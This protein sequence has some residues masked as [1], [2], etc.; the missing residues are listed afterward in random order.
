MRTR[1]HRHEVDFFVIP[2]SLLPPRRA[3]TAVHRLL[4]S[5]VLGVALCVCLSAQ[6][7]SAAAD[8]ADS[9]LLER[10]V[11]AAY[12]YKFLSYVD[13]PPA[14]FA[15]PVSPYV[16]AIAGAD[17]VASELVALTK[18]RTVNNRT[19][20]VKRVNFGDSMAGV[21]LLFVGQQEASRQ[22]QWLH[23]G[24]MRAVLTV[25]ENDLRLPEGS[26]INFRQVEG[27][28]R[29]E[30]SLPAAERNDLK[31]SSRMLAVALN[32]QHGY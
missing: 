6:R 12:L 20:T 8:D 10:S 24:T 32:V 25:T 23:L 2:I 17:P 5:I 29:F 18:G 31:L 26:V 4:A 16:I 22:A 27:R 9:G 3:M 1:K 19:V 7:C 11:K 21:H 30:V 13:W 14:A 28:I 15:Q